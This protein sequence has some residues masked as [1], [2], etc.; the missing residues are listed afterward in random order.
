MVTIMRVQCQYIMSFVHVITLYP[1][2]QEKG[3][4]PS[5]KEKGL[6]TAVECFSLGCV[7]SCELANAMSCKLA[8]EIRLHQKYVIIDLVNC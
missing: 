6:V 4:P 3:F 8:H 7:I 5:H 1:K 2:L